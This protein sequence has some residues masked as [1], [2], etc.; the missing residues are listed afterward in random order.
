[1]AKKIE[2]NTFRMPNEAKMAKKFGLISLWTM[3]PMSLVTLAVT[4]YS[5][6]IGGFST[7]TLVMGGLCFVLAGMAIAAYIHF[8]NHADYEFETP[9]HGIKLVFKSPKYYVPPEMF[10]RAIIE[11]SLEAFRP[12]HDK[13]DK[14]MTEGI[15][16]KVLDE[17]PI[18]WA[19][20]EALGM[21]WAESGVSR[22]WGPLVLSMRLSG[23]ELKLHFCHRLYPGRS[24][25]EDIAWMKKKGIL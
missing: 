14:E 10:E 13:T 15:I 16:F 24:E 9:E 18:H 11:P 25:A 20:G 21:T 22:I 1:M 2:P 7:A 8:K 3:A 23:Y 19:V 17:K 5:L 12:H 4:I 6:V